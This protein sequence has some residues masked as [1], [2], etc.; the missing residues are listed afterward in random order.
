MPDTGANRQTS[1]GVQLLYGDT[2]DSITNVVADLKSFP[3]MI[4]APDKIE[5]T[6]MGDT[7]RTYQ[8]GLSDPGDMQFI[9]AFSGMGSGTNWAALSAIESADTA[10]HWKLRFPDGSAFTWQGKV[11]LSMPG[12][13][14]AEALEFAANISAS[15]EIIAVTP[16]A[17]GEE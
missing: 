8:P 9:F 2:A 3:D 16:D 12:K 7:Q 10:K 17:G 1:I 4:G 13:G 11:R 14:I 5:T 15:S 6:T